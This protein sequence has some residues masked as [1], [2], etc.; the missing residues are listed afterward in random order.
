MPANHQL[1]LAIIM[2]LRQF[3]YSKK[4]TSTKVQF[5][6]RRTHAL[7][8]SR[9]P[10]VIEIRNNYTLQ[11]CFSAVA[12]RQLYLSSVHACTISSRQSDCYPDEI[13]IFF[14]YNFS[15]RLHKVW[16][17]HMHDKVLCKLRF[18]ACSP[19]SLSVT[20]MHSLF[21]KKDWTLKV[22]VT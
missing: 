14:T 3:Q 10:I 13:P 6:L 1:Q 8:F 7:A 5:S 17:K 20:R 11:T 12:W 9:V 19:M 18:K 2:L 15:H 22:L 16:N 4:T 21:P